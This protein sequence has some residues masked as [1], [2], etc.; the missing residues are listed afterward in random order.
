MQPNVNMDS[1]LT[2][3]LVTVSFSHK[4]SLN[5]TILQHRLALYEFKS[6]F[7]ALKSMLAF[8]FIIFT[9]FLFFEQPVGMTW[10]GTIRIQECKD[11]LRRIF[12]QFWI[13]TRSFLGCL[14]FILKM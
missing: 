11:T 10:L 13:K 14:N 8:F 2:F 9:H 5:H 6:L 1:R 12:H 3:D 7:L 4:E